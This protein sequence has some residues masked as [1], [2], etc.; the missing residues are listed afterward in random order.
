MSEKKNENY[1]ISHH[2]TT[3]AWIKFGLNLIDSQSHPLFLMF[4]SNGEMMMN[5]F[6]LAI[7]AMDLSEFEFKVKFKIILRYRMART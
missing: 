1:F 2:D 3:Y 6:F 4:I 5:Y 7:Y